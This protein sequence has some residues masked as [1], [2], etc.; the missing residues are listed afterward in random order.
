M[1]AMERRSGLRNLRGVPDKVHAG[2][3]SAHQFAFGTCLNW[4]KKEKQPNR[5][6]EGSLLKASKSKIG[7]AFM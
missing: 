2:I 3:S 1:K 5:T 4:E 7:W 6:L